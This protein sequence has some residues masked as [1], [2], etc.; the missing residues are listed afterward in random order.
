METVV[1]NHSTCVFVCVCKRLCLFKHKV[2]W[3]S[4]Q[5]ASVDGEEKR[6]QFSSIRVSVCTCE[7]MSSLSV[8]SVRVLRVF[9]CAPMLWELQYTHTLTVLHFRRLPF[10]ARHSF[11]E[12]WSTKAKKN[13]TQLLIEIYFASMC[14]PC[15]SQIK[16]H[17]KRRTK[18]LI[19]FNQN[20]VIICRSESNRT[21]FDELQGKKLAILPMNV[22]F[23]LLLLLC[24][25][26]YALETKR[27][28]YTLPV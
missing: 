14:M 5:W 11:G 7:W 22:F 8:L 15:I 17:R 20:N 24:W 13:R 6:I 3:K 26:L 19:K 27:D 16:V 23:S 12:T 9:H 25:C 4:N 1:V 10:H 18:K 2:F 28:E 21:V